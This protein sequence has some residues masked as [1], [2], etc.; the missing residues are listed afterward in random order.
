MSQTL[1]LYRQQIWTP[2]IRSRVKSLLFRH[3]IC[4]RMKGRIVPKP[5]PPPLPKGRVQWQT[6]FT[7]V[8]VDHTGYF[9]IRDTSGEK[10]KAYV[11]LFVCATTRVVHLEAISYFSVQ[12]F[13]L[14]LRRLAAAK[15]TTSMILSDNHRTFISGERFLL[16]MQDDPKV[17]EYLADHRIVWRHQTS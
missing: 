2:K 12:S 5:L 9:T 6:P 11:C 14:C 3:V 1:S 16:E 7:T 4:R 10:R 17:Q 15:G 13:L 8:G